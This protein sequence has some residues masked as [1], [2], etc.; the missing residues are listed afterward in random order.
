MMRHADTQ[1][2]LAEV[3]LGQISRL[4]TSQQLHK[5]LFFN[6]MALSPK[7]VPVRGA[8][9]AGF[10]PATFWSQ[11]Q[12]PNWLGALWKPSGGPNQANPNQA[13]PTTPNP[14]TPNQRKNPKKS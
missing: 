5:L 9:P 8:R 6:A 11:A 12:P 14:T 7:V 3:M 13:N 4:P 1:A 2:C 10:D